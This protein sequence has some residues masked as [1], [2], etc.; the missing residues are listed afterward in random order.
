MALFKLGVLN[1]RRS[2]RFYRRLLLLGFGIG[3]PIAAYGVYTNFAAGWDVRYSFFLGS[4]FNDWASI[5]VALGWVGTVM[6]ACRSTAF[7]QISP[8]LA[9]VGRM[10]F[11]N[12]I[13]QTLICTTI[14]YGHG[15][16]FFGRVDRLGQ[17]GIVL[18]IWA[19]ELILS[20]LWLARFQFGPLEW[21]W[22]CLTYWRRQPF[23]KLQPSFTR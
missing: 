9:A 16:G 18:M 13:L 12:Y 10:A 4:Q 8:V 2:R 17:V 15:L 22:R 19:L 14:F 7:A 1:A 11:S 6:L 21:L 23:L 5:P 3:I 20:P